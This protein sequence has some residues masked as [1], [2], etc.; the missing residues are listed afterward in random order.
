MKAIYFG[1]L[2]VAAWMAIALC[3]AS[4]IPASPPAER[5]PVVESHNTFALDLYGRLRGQE[6]NVFF[7]PYSMA[8]AL[9]M[10]YA[11]ARAE[12]AEQMAKV[13]HL[14]VEQEQVPG[15]FAAL[16]ASL[17]GAGKS[18]GYELYTANAL[19]GQ[20]GHPF[21]TAF[22]KLTHDSYH[23][24]LTEV[25]FQNATEQARQTINAWVEKQTHDKIKELLAPGVL[26][27]MT[28]LVLTNAIY[29]KGDWAK[30]FKK[31]RTRD[32]LFHV[33]ARQ[34]T[35]VPMM[36]QKEHFGYLEDA[37]FQALE[38][39]YAGKDLALVVLLPRKVDGL[40]A[41]E[42]SLTSAKL[43][44]WLGKL[45]A[46]EVDV[47]LPKFQLTE[48]LQL[49]KTL[50]EMGMPNAFNSRADFS[51]MDGSHDLFLSAV[52][53]KAFVDVN[54]KGTEAAAAT[55]VAVKATAMLANAP[56]FRADHPFLFLIR[57]TR[58][59]SILFMGRLIQPEK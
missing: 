32:E 16:D 5:K 20:K 13:L 18:R 6:G 25:D 47:A 44:T 33:R 38:L 7:S 11:G 31:E 30:P 36:H 19:W 45:H 59:G 10:T 50:S 39:P 9:A 1:F 43:T 54:E 42:R 55:G 41:L 46:V 52:V 53:H 17:T 4:Q 49:A 26:S 8:T 12:T 24:G 35:K 56:V 23:A 3:C 21:L 34:E 57:D 51:G 40:A 15:A 37:A 58:S 22:I 29:F 2:V 14:P 27:D 48:E 28:R